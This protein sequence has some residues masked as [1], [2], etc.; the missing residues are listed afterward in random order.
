MKMA[1]QNAIA[2]TMIGLLIGCPSATPTSPQPTTPPPSPPPVAPSV[3]RLIENP[4]AQAGEPARALVGEGESYFVWMHPA[5]GAP[6]QALYTSTDGSERVFVDFDETSGLPYI[7]VDDVSGG[8]VIIEESVPGRVDYYFH[9]RE[10]KYD[11]GHA[12]FRRGKD[13]FIGDIL[14]VSPFASNQI[15]GQLDIDGSEDSG[16]FAISSDIE[17]GLDS[18]LTNI[19]P[20]ATD[21]VDLMSPLF[22]QVSGNDGVLLT[23]I[24]GIFA[25]THSD[26]NADTRRLATSTV[27]TYIA[28][29]LITVAITALVANEFASNAI[30]KSPDGKS[31]IKELNLFGSAGAAEITEESGQIKTN[32]NKISSF[33]TPTDLPPGSENTLTGTTIFQGQGLT[34][35]QGT[36]NASGKFS[37]ENSDGSL[38][39]VGSVGGG[40]SVDGTF[41]YGN[42]IGRIIDGKVQ[43]PRVLSGI[44]RQR[45]ARQLQLCSLCWARCRHRGLFLRYLLYTRCYLGQLGQ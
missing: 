31:I 17:R 12:V 45:R 41:T 15:T 42:L 14:S 35:V 39:I 36:I 9:D 32:E 33:P 43:I 30:L 29:F 27:K 18:G 3:Y 38:I 5:T 6:E 28:L 40:G 34:Q 4:N 44:L 23:I 37:V 8:F 26:S 21:V 10:G 19:R 22:D 2:A 24:I 11:T 16:S 20:V 7:A 13:W 1:L 25:L